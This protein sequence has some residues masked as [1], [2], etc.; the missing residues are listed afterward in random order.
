VITRL[1]IFLPYHEQAFNFYKHRYQM[2]KK[3]GYYTP[4]PK[5]L[6]IEQGDYLFEEYEKSNPENIPSHE[7]L[8]NN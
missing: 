5:E 1:P 7:T 2:S 3:T 6:V 8:V 4:L